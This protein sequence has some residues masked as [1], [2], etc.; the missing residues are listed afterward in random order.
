MH[1]KHTCR[2]HNHSSLTGSQ[3]NSSLWRH[4]CEEGSSDRIPRCSLSLSL[5]GT[6]LP[7]ALCPPL[8][9]RGPDYRPHPPHH[10]ALD[11]LLESKV[12]LSPSTVTSNR[13]G[14]GGGKAY[15]FFPSICCFGGVGCSR[16][17]PTCFVGSKR[18]EL[19]PRSIQL[20]EPLWT[21]PPSTFS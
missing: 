2:E 3:H 1:G 11:H 5:Q 16:S 9:S 21:S 18:G 10:E 14:S 17:F 8:A 6:P 19:K 7:A 20:W 15:W 12:G 13:L 4:H